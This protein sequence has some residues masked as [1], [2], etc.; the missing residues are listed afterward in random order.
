MCPAASSARRTT[1]TWPSIIPDG[2]TTCDPGG[3]LGH[4]H[5]GVRGE[6]RVVVHRAVGG[7]QPAVPVRGELVQAQ[8]AHHHGGVADLGDHVPDR[9]VE[10]AVRVDAAGAGRVPV[11]RHAEQHDPADAGLDRL[12]GR[13]A[14]RVP[15]V[16]DHPRACEAIG[17]GSVS[18]SL[19]NI[20]S[21]Q[22]GR[23]DAGLRDQPP[24]RPGCAAAGAGRI[25]GYGMTGPPEYD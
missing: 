5:L 13:L 23:V 4:R 16:L 21:D 12:G 22:L 19:T 1:P 18:P 2:P 24:Q 25:S 20:G 9:D 17:R 7:E 6:G 3:G 11:A 10:D 15:G 14:Q 8:V